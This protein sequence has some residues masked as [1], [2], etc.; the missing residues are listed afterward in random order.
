MIEYRNW[1]K[2]WN[3]K[4]SNLDHYSLSD[5]LELDGFDSDS[6]FIDEKSWLLYLDY[7]AF[8]LKYE[9]Y[10]SIFEVGCGS[11]AFLYP[12]YKNK[13][14]VSGIDYSD[15]LTNICS[16]VMP[17]M[18]FEVCEAINLNTSIKFDCVLSN[19]V[20]QYFPDYSY[21]EKVVLKMIDKSKYKIAI[22]DL[23]DINLESESRIIRKGDLSEKEYQERYRGLK[24]LFF[25][26]IFF[27]EIV[28]RR[29]CSLET[30][31]QKSDLY[32]QSSFRFNVIITK[33]E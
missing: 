33:N 5:L 9:K 6:G 23:N 24:H 7:I 21:A 14:L 11:G 2:I 8:H 15:R 20:F 10:H 13:S 31:Q 26:R 32:A 29:N 4:N 1:K 27:E 18:Q 30:Y 28:L 17:D 22:L 19:S 12:F 3:N 16:K 25:D